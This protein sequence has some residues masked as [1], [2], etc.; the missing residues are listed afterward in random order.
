[1]VKIKHD[2]IPAQISA[3][4]KNICYDTSH[5]CIITDIDLHGNGFIFF[6][7]EDIRPG[8]SLEFTISTVPDKTVLSGSVQNKIKLSS[9]KY[10]TAAELAVTAASRDDTSALLQ[11]ALCQLDHLEKRVEL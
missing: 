2:S 10:S 1:M 11:Y 7:E 8:A 3:E 6:T 5:E 4:Y 9:G